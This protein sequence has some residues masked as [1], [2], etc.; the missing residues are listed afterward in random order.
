MTD[1]VRVWLVGREYTD[2]GLVTLTYATPDG[3]RALVEQRS[4]ANLGEVTAAREVAP[5]R[6]TPVEAGDRERYAMEVERVADRN[7]PDDAI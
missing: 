3:E 4:A 5:D 7:D 1:D 2:K 6:L